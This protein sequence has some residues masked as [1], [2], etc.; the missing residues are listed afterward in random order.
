MGNFVEPMSPVLKILEIKFFSGT[1]GVANSPKNPRTYDDTN[2][3]Q[4]L[5]IRMLDTYKVFGSHFVT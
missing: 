1:E 4:S 2:Y 3:F 5:I